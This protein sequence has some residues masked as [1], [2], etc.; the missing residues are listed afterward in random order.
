MFYPVKDWY[1]AS[2]LMVL[3]VWAPGLTHKHCLREDGLMY[4]FP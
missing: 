3:L 2:Y 1:P 4:F